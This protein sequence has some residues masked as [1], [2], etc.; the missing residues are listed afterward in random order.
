VLAP[1]AE[2]ALE[3]TVNVTLL[4]ESAVNEA[5]PD[6]PVPDVAIVKVPLFGV[7]TEAQVWSPRKYVDELATPEAKRAVAT[8]PLD[9]LDAFKVVKLAPET[10]PKEPDQVPEVIVPTEVKL[11]AVV[12]FG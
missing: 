7:A 12:M 8:V 4:D 5:E 6:K 10:A 2:A 1:L 11:A 3:V 9:K